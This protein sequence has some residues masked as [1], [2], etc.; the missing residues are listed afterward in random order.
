MNIKER[1]LIVEDEIS[2]A[3]FMSSVLEKEGYRVI[4]A[5]TGGEALSIID[6]H[7]PDLVILDLG[8][9][10]MDGMSVLEQLRQ[11][12]NVPVLVVSARTLAQNL[13]GRRQLLPNAALAASFCMLAVSFFGF[14]TRGV[15]APLSDPQVF[16][17]KD[18]SLKTIFTET[19]ANHR[20]DSIVLGDEYSALSCF[21]YW[22]V[23]AQPGRFDNGIPEV[24]ILDDRELQEGYKKAWPSYFGHADVPWD[25][26][27]ANMNLV[28]RDS[29]YSVYV[30]R[31]D[32]S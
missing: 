19:L 31:D 8:L 1:I 3:R 20:T 5:V 11:W 24:V 15:F 18:A 12:S 23:D 7:C 9:P 16:Q 28:Y 32:R 17:Q 13:H 6:S 25:Y 14:Q 2:I 21:Y 29:A 10:D 22:N 4:R 26:I 27:N 30:R